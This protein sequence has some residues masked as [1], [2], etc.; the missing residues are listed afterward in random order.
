MLSI[1]GVQ[2]YFYMSTLLLSLEILSP[3]FQQKYSIPNAEV[4]LLCFFLITLV[5]Q[6]FSIIFYKASFQLKGMKFQ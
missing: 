4:L 2:M 1:R 5:L 3:Y 6:Q